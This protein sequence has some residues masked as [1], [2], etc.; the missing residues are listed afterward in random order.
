MNREEG[1][2]LSFKAQCDAAH[3]TFNILN[4]FT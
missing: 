3:I 4:A 2:P 1:N